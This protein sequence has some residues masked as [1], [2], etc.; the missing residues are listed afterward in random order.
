MLYTFEMTNLKISTSV[1]IQTFKSNTAAP[2]REAPFS[3]SW[4]FSGLEFTQ[5]AGQT[6]IWYLVLV[7]LT[8]FMNR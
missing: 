7:N 6:Y 8:P 1:I 3:F 2:N 5:T 4:P